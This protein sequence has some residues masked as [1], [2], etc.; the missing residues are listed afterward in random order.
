ML[1]LVLMDSLQVIPGCIQTMRSLLDIYCIIFGLL[2]NTGYRHILLSDLLFL[3][4][5][6]GID[7]ADFF[8]DLRF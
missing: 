1:C 7:N 2:L 8:D 5:Q 6:P 4:A 3:I